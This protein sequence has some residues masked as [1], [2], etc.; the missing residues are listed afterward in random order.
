M[1]GGQLRTVPPLAAGFIVAIDLLAVALTTVLTWVT[2]AIGRD[3][4]IAFVVL[5]VLGVAAAEYSRG[6]ERA[7]RRF[8]STVAPYVNLNSVWTMAGAVVLPPPLAAALVVLIYGHT[9]W[10]IR[11][12][13]PYRWIFNVTLVILSVDVAAAMAHWPWAQFTLAP[14]RLVAVI[15]LAVVVV[16]YAVTNLGLA[17]AAL[18]LLRDGRTLR[19]V[20]GTWHEAGIEGATL[21]LGILT[22]LMVAHYPVLLILLPLPLWMLEHAVRVPALENAITR[23][24]SGALHEATWRA[25]ADLELAGARKRGESL[26]I[27]ALTLDN[28]LSRLAA[29]NGDDVVD[30]VMNTVVTAIRRSLRH[31]DLCGR[32]GPTALVIALPD[33]DLAAA[34]A[35]A[36][37]LCDLVRTLVVD[38]PDDV[39][40]P[41]GS[42]ADEPVPVALSVSVGVAAFPAG[43]AT[44]DAVLTAASA[45]RFAS[46]SSGGDQVRASNRGDAQQLAARDGSRLR[47]R[48]SRTG[49]AGIR[50]A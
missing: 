30:R 38:Q 39:M 21:C 40:V 1:R 45:A 35:V 41:A 24:T 18:L 8:K 47:R 36:R 9:W 3:A 44:L 49:R 22:A 28:G 33:T 27:L 5:V 16:S 32:S 6:V 2:H 10:R 19:E 7:R 14:T 13:E 42:P 29:T 48:E 23:D 34:T 20:L 25:Y 12:T 17:A 4:M 11:R 43:G 50:S 37:R 46:R 15:G 31:D 26:G